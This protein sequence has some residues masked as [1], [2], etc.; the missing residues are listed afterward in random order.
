MR[1]SVIVVCSL[2]RKA[3]DLRAVDIVRIS[4]ADYH[5][6]KWTLR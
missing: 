3:V 1:C 4:E 6:E 2:Q 5:G